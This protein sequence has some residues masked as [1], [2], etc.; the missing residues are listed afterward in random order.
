MGGL[1][2]KLRAETTGS[3]MLCLLHRL[4][5]PPHG[6]PASSAASEI[7]RAACSRRPTGPGPAGSFVSGSAP[8]FPRVL[9]MTREATGRAAQCFMRRM[10]PRERHDDGRFRHSQSN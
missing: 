2:E 1:G 6:A 5:R 4:G 8:L 10:T 9:G 7:P 3:E